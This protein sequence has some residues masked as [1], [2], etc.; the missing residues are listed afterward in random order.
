MNLLLLPRETLSYSCCVTCMW[1]APD[2]D[3]ETQEIVHQ[4]R[5][6]MLDLEE[7]IP[8]NAVSKAWK[9]RRPG[10]RKTVRS[11]E[12]ISELA[13]RLRDLLSTLV[14]EKS[15]KAAHGGRAW[16]NEVEMIVKGK[17]GVQDRCLKTEEF[18]LASLHPIHG[19]SCLGLDIYLFKKLLYW[20]LL[21]STIF[22]YMCW[23]EAQVH[24]FFYRSEELLSAYRL[25]FR[26]T[27]GMGIRRNSG[28]C[29]KLSLARFADGSKSEIMHPSLFLFECL[30]T[31]QQELLL[32]LW[33][34]QHLMGKKE[35]SKWVWLSLTHIS[36]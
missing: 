9:S 7:F 26:Q 6:Q 3:A 24:R 17:Y 11:T 15:W 31:K 13:E 8:W 14:W 27:K 23:N 22:L 2:L 16:E 25:Q 28:V 12:R 29:G 10:W 34:K 19:W 20:V 30:H 36:F 35:L 4:V 33:R 5:K 32:Q 18:S 21:S 1:C